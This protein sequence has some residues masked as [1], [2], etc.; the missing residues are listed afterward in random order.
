MRILQV[1]Q[2][3][4]EWLEARAGKITGS[5]LKDIV[6][7][8]GNA[9]KDG[10]Y[11]LLADR[12]SVG[13]ENSSSREDGHE[14]E[15][16][17]LA[18]FAQAYKK[19]VDDNCGIWVSDDNENIAISPDAGIKNKKGVYT[20][21][22]EVK[23]LSGKHHLR[24]I[25]ENTIGTGFKLQATQYFVVNEDLQTL[26]FVFYDPRITAKPLHVI[27]ITREELADDIEFYREYEEKVLNWVDEWAERLAF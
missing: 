5:K 26:Y 20:E 23:C 7:F 12:L 4:P 19:K 6:V 18:E 24:A 22:V 2:N 16:Q 9:V 15:K 8:K 1:E 3:T 21:A 25:I 14:K 27:E 13:Y 17:A 11:E 10:Q